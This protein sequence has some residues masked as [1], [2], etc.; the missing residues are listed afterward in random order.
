MLDALKALFGRKPAEEGAEPSPQLAATTLLVEAALSDGVY[1]D[2]ESDRILEILRT[3]FD[4]DESAAR[5]LL[6]EAE[7]Q[8][9]AAVDHYKFTKVVKEQLP[10]SQRERLVEHLFEVA[11]A[12]GE[13]APVEDAFIRRVAPLLAVDD[14][15]RVMARQ[16]AEDAGGEGD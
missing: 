2:L 6:E 9:E 7:E 11:I 14:R 8:A 13:R 16:R 10:L 12:D 3:A 5:A 4:L 1:A 15:A